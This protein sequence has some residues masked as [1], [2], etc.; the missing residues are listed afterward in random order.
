M[1]LFM[2][3]KPTLAPKGASV[4]LY[5]EQYLFFNRNSVILIRATIPF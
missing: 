3:D 5:W 1:N 2:I 4:V